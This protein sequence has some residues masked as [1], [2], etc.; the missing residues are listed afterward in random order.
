MRAISG[1]SVG[2]HVHLHITTN[3][4]A[5]A[6][7]APFHRFGH[8]QEN[9]VPGS[10]RGN[11]MALELIRVWYEDQNGDV[12]LG[13]AVWGSAIRNYNETIQTRSSILIPLKLDQM[14]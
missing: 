10:I 12:T 2:L 8:K 1:C 11:S 4:Q 6:T 3:S 9:A 14:A 5:H 7:H 13:G